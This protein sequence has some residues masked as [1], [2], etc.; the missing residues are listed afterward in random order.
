MNSMRYTQ[1]VRNIIDELATL[2]DITNTTTAG[3]DWADKKFNWY[4]AI[5]AEV[6]EAIDSTSYKWWKK[7]EADLDNLKVEIVDILHFALSSDLSRYGHDAIVN[8]ARYGDI[9]EV[10]PSFVQNVFEEE[11]EDFIVTLGDSIASRN[12]EPLTPRAIDL[13]AAIGMDI[14]E[15]RTRYI[16][17]NALNKLRQAHGYKDGSYIKEWNGAEDNVW[18]TVYIQEH[19]GVSFD[20]VYRVLDK[21]Y[22]K[23]IVKK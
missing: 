9:N 3:E 17:K 13:A 14:D 20:E 5:L 15:V 10:Q 18:A 8:K 11:I 7:T 6:G 16:G 22:L 23:N 2:Q 4:M 19:P 1:Q 21:F 12:F